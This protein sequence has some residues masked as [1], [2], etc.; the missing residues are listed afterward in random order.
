K[1]N[2]AKHRKV[3]GKKKPPKSRTAI[4]RDSYAKNKDKIPQKLQEKRVY[5]QFRHLE[6]A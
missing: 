2:M 5:D 1:S 4:N 3:C 6:G